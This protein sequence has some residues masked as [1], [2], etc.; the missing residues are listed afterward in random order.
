[1]AY[2]CPQKIMFKH[3]DPAGIVFY[4]RYFEM[5]NDCVEAFFEERLNLPFAA[6]HSE[7]AVP[8]AEISTRFTAPSRLGD[9]LTI[10]LRVTRLGRTSL[11]LRLT[12][13]CGEETRFETTS[14]L[15][16]VDRD[17]RPTAWP[18][19]VREKINAC[20]ENDNDA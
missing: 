8:T 1:M 5:M 16:M 18:A 12:A 14:T 9:E 20:L 15:V 13:L 4:P 7:G 11:G 17:G 3:C 6:L 19:E 10:G 2:S